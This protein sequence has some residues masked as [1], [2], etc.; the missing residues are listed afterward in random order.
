MGLVDETIVAVLPSL[1]E[2]YISTDL[3]VSSTA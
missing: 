2:R 3:F 1:A